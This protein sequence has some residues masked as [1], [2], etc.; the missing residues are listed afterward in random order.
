MERPKRDCGGSKWWGKEAKNERRRVSRIMNR[1]EGLALQW[2]LR[3]MT[4]KYIHLRVSAY[5]QSFGIR[6][7]HSQYAWKLSTGKRRDLHL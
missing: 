2:A 3:E 7:W 5:M 6:G 1:W 4:R